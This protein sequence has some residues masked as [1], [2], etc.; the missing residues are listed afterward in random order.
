VVIV[1]A[2][3]GGLVLALTLQKL[4][5]PFK[6]LERSSSENVGE[7]LNIT[8]TWRLQ[9]AHVAS[10]ST[11]VKKQLTF[12]KLREELGVRAEAAPLPRL[13]LSACL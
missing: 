8:Q 7:A 10:L 6:M 12:S 4:G 5:L 2:G 9:A 11:R 13:V 1:G 3:V